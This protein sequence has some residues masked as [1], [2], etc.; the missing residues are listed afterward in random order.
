M[1]RKIL[2]FFRLFIYLLIFFM[3][4]LGLCCYGWAFSIVE[5]GSYPLV[6]AHRLLSVVASLV[7]EHGL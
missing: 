3:D 5:S 4:A 1:L 7:V 6:A 2:F